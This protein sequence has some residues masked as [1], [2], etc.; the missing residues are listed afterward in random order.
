MI[1]ETATS[2]PRY[3]EPGKR[4]QVRAMMSSVR[5][6]NRFKPLLS[7]ETGKTFLRR[8]QNPGNPAFVAIPG[9]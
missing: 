8:G 3:L 7:L 6:L 2:F 4:F 1:T 5:P 9:Q